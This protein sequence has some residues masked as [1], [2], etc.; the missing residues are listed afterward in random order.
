MVTPLD[1]RSTDERDPAAPLLHSTAWHTDTSVAQARAALRA[2]LAQAGYDPDHRPGQDAQLIVSELTSNAL[3]HAPGPGSL[4]LEVTPDAD[5]LRIT[6]SDTSQR[7]P[8]LQTHDACRVGGHGLRLVT[9]LSDR[10]Y[11]VAL[12]T[13]KQ[14][15]AH[16]YL[17]EPAG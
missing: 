3:R 6:V 13:G 4:V 12:G 1:K 15:V 14:V 9:R 8:E 16:L 17:R 5:L 11:T 2:L 10:L 7:L